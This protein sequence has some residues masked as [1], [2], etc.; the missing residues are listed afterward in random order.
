M[1]PSGTIFAEIVNKNIWLR[2]CIWKCYLQISGHFVQ[3]LMCDYMPINVWVSEVCALAGVNSSILHPKIGSSLFKEMSYGCFNAKPLPEPMLTYYWLDPKEQTWNW[4]PNIKKFIW[5][6]AFA[7]VCQ[8]SSILS[9]PL[10]IKLSLSVVRPWDLLPVSCDI[11]D[12]TQMAQVVSHDEDTPSQLMPHHTVT[13]RWHPDGTGGLTWWGQPITT[14]ATSHCDRGDGTQMAQVVS[15]DEDMPSQLTPHHTVTGEMA[16]RWHRW[17][18]MM[19]TAHHNSCHITLWQGRWHPDGTGGLTWWG[20]PITTHATSHCDREMA[21]RWHRWSHMMRT[22]HHNSRHITLWQGRWHPDGTD[23][24]TWWGH[25]ITTHTTSHCDRGDGT[26]MAQVVSHDEDSPSQL[27]PHH[28]VT[29]EMAPRW[30]RWSHMMRTCHHNSHHIT[31]W[32]GRWHPDG[33]GGLTWW[34]HTITI[35]ASSYSP[36][37]GKQQHVWLHHVDSQ[38]YWLPDDMFSVSS[39]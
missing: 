31:L 25:A 4:I 24:L 27:T 37:T 16:P 2:K 17:S 19:R 28:T 3:A 1:W 22:A 21:P 11:G 7:N 38:W 12:G 35:H 34:G 30:H 20:Q 36:W 15:H 10:C 32:Q 33:T 6:N 5:E 8:M 23:G 39:P 9:H 18:H 26:Q 14:H 29:G 13:G